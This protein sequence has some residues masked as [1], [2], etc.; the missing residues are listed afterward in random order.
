MV[1][2]GEN[3]ILMGTTGKSK[4][5]QK[6]ESPIIQDATCMCRAHPFQLECVQSIS[7]TSCEAVQPL[8]GTSCGAMY[9]HDLHIMEQIEQDSGV[10]AR[11]DVL[12][13][14]VEEAERGDLEGGRSRAENLCR[15]MI[16]LGF[17]KD[18]PGMSL[19]QIKELLIPFFGEELVERVSSEPF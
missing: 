12:E 6:P 5:R 9:L 16:T 2:I 14:R 19:S 11:A 10:I 8:S 4:T 18:K 17:M 3:G 13:Q 7:G 1:L 15:D